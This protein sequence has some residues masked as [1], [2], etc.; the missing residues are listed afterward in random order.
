VYNGLSHNKGIALEYDLEHKLSIVR[1]HLESKTTILF[2]SKKTGVPV[3]QLRAWVKAYRHQIEYGIKDDQTLKGV[4]RYESWKDEEGN[5]QA[6]WVKT[7]VKQE[8]ILDKLKAFADEIKAELPRAPIVRAPTIIHDDLLNFY[9]LTDAHIGMRSD[10]WNLETAKKV[11]KGWFQYVA[12][13]MPDAHTGVLCFQ[14][15]IAHW[16]SMKPLTPSIGHVLD[17]DCNSREMTRAIIQIIKYAVDL[18]LKKHQELK[19]IYVAGNH[20]EYSAVVQSE[21]LSVYY[22]DNPRIHVDTKN[23]LYHCIEWGDVSIFT[24]HGHKRKITDI[25]KVFAGMYREVFGRTKYS[26]GHIGHYHHCKCDEDQLMQI[27]IHPTLSGK[28]DY[29]NNGGW[30][31]QRGAKAICYHKKYGEVDYTTGRPEMFL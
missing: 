2:T 9:V 25:T 17:A 26:Y 13:R 16:D 27:Q 11:I 5:T 24:H 18:L 28:D 1:S 30:L 20:D 3:N 23:T 19:V 31:S 6:Q 4:S 29:A 12:K 14:G 7:D 8:A 22:S 21:W 15:D 10:D